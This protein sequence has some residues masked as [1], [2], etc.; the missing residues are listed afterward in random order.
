[1][2]PPG[3]TNCVS[4]L[5]HPRCRPAV[6][7]GERVPHHDWQQ[8]ALHIPWLQEH[9]HCAICQEGLTPGEGSLLVV[10]AVTGVIW[11]YR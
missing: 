11:S 5:I 6:H 9:K 7:I 4:V 10:H 2:H 8:P 1:M 3:E